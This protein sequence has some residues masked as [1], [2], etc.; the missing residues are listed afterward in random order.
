MLRLTG[1]VTIVLVVACLVT[2]MPAGSGRCDGIVTGGLDALETGESLGPNLLVN[3]DL[4]A[5]LQGWTFNP[6]CFSL[7]GSGDTASLRLQEPCAQPVP[8]AENAFKCPPGL[9]TIS[10]DIK[11]QTTNTVPK[12][13]A[14]TRIRLIES[15]GKKWAMTNPPAI[16]ATDWTTAVKAHIKVSD[17]STSSF[18]AETVG[19]VAGTSWFRKLFLGRENPAPLETFLLYPNYRGMMFSDQSQVARVAI[20]V[21]PP[22]DTTMA[23]LHVALDLT[24]S[25]GKVLSTLRLAPPADGSTIATVDMGRLPLGRY[26]LQGYLEGP[27]NKRILA[28]SPYTIAKVSGATRNS[29][30]AWIDSDNIIHMGGRPRFVIGLYDTTGFGYRTSYFAPRLT[31]IAKAPINL[32]IN[33]FLNHGLTNYIHFYTEAM[34][35][36]GHFLP[37]VSTHIFPGDESL[38]PVGES[39]KR[40]P[41]PVSCSVQQGIGQRS[42]RGRLLHV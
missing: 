38:S 21:H 6:S 27:G 12:Q 1:R 15:S 31:A 10:A 14:G 16:G 33:Y 36:L 4:R 2:I 22:A 26:R 42:P 40:R 7:E 29:M 5:G 23:Q 20:D 8:F 28:Q 34:A 35:P 24:D 17:G 41:G 11:T 30:K 37:G 3:G 18:R 19:P 13:H 25:G 39:A 32:M 9:Y